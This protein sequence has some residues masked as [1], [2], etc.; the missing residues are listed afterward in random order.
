MNGKRLTY[1]SNGLL[2]IGA[3]L[4]VYIFVSIFLAYRSLPAG[5][6]PITDNRPLIIIDVVILLTSLVLSFFEKKTTAG[7]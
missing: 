4:A 2:I 3:A 7:R 6:C 5:A 1:L